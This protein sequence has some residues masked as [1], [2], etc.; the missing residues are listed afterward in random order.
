MKAMIFAAGLGTRLKP[1]TDTLPKALIPVA[2]KPL[3]E[4]LILKMK[5]AGITDITINVH[6]FAEK[7][8]S[9]LAEKNEF[10]IQIRISHEQ[11]QL[12]ETGGGIRHAIPLLTQ[13]GTDSQEPVLIH[14][15]DIISNLDLQEFYTAHRAADATLLVSSRDTQR[16]LLFNKENRLVGWT[17][18]ETG[19]VKSPYPDLD[20][21]ACRKYAFAGIHLFSPRL[22][23]YL[24]AWNGPFSIIDFYLS[25]A[26]QVQIRAFPK[27]DLRLIDVGKLHSLS[28]AETFLAEEGKK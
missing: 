21:S 20:V 17:N 3:L 27:E 14:N 23:P 19:A 7:I 11:H 1:L 16:Y 25:L 15:V 26:D 12:L 9:F 8:R 2:G 4:H 13:Q 24:S 28:Q 10:G 18:V 5:A 6:H 22:F